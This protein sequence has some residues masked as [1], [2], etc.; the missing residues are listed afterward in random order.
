MKPKI[1]ELLKVLDLPEEKQVTWISKT[2]ADSWDWRNK[3][4]LNVFELAFR[5]RD[6][7]NDKM[8]GRAFG[9]IAA[10]TS[11]RPNAEMLKNIPQFVLGWVLMSKPI[12]WIIAALIAKELDINH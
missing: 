3:P 11:G 10:E 12:H 2:F 1:E 6:E 8:F 4:S 5:L 7:A 9:I